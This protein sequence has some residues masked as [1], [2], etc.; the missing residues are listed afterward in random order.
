MKEIEN[1]DKIK[2]FC[3][4]NKD[5]YELIEVDEQIREKLLE[6][7][8]KLENNEDVSIL[9]RG[10][11]ENKEFIDRDLNKFFI[12]GDKSKFYFTEDRGVYSDIFKN[13]DILIKNI[14]KLVKQIKKCVKSKQKKNI[15]MDTE[16]N[17]KITGD[18]SNKD[19]EDLRYLY[20]MLL[21]MHHNIG[22]ISH[23][24]KDSPFL[25]SAGGLN[26]FNEAKDFALFKNEKNEKK[27]IVILFY[28]HKKSWYSLKTKEL[29]EFLKEYNINWFDD[30]HCETMILDGI[31]THYIIGIFD[32]GDKNKYNFIINPWLYKQFKN[33]IELDVMDGININ[34]SKLEE[35]A[36]ELGYKKVNYD[37][38][39]ERPRTIVQLEDN[40][41]SFGGYV[42][43]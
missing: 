17:D 4:N 14:I 42:N 18:L 11:K 41:T 21:A 26:L 33:D 23:I 19:I 25:S 34:Q 2:S 35:Y 15:M 3:P 39:N 22:E 30:K 38:G 28:N 13:N 10:K 43:R 5:K 37:S 9:V 12:V 27:S 29:N 40:K 1:V 20:I 16:I 6:T 32:F 36:A 7:L 31:Y 24:K 8:N